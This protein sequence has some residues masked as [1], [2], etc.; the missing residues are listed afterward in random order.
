MPFGLRNAAQTFQRFINEVLNG[1]K[2]C[3]A[4][5]DDILVASTSEE[6]HEI[7]LKQLFTRL[8]KYGVRINPVK[9]I[10]GQ[11]EVSFL[12]YLVSKKGTQPLPEKIEAIR[13]FPKLNNARQLRQFLGTINFYRRF[14]PGAAEEQAPLNDAL[15]RPKT[16]GK[17]LVQWSTKMEEVFRK[18]KEGLSRATLLAHPDPAASLAVTTDASATAIGAVIQQYT[19]EGWQPLAFLSKKLSK[20]QTQYSPC[21]LELL[22]VYIT[23]KHYR[24]ML[25]GRTFTVYTDHKPLIHAFKQDPLH[26]SPRQARHLEYIGQFT[27]DIQHIEG[28]S[29][30]VADTLSRVEAIQQPVDLELLTKEQQKDEELQ[31]LQNDISKIKLTQMPIPGSTE[32]VLC[33]T[34]ILLPRPYVPLSLRKQAFQLLHGLAHPGTKASAK[35]VKQRY[36]WP[37]MQ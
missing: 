13:N 33:N 21:D 14:I 17:A 15:R 30:V 31:R 9:C 20:T 37:S 26:S 27:T 32:T 22:A 36:V 35:L 6:Q 18:C 29:N 1:L 3:Y 25:E 11:E 12:G 34:S 24:H 2:F 8:N 7:H 19:H 28:K 10:L 4:Y 16:K 5:I 23:I